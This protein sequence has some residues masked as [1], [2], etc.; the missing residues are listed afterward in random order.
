MS[1]R[2]PR[3]S[4]LGL[5]QVLRPVTSWHALGLH[6]NVPA[7]QLDDIARRLSHEGSERCKA[8]LFQL[9]LRKLPSVGWEEVIAALEKT[10]QHKLAGELKEKLEIQAAIVF[11]CSS[12]DDL[13]ADFSSLVKTVKRLLKE[14]EVKVKSVQ[15]CLKKSLNIRHSHTPQSIK[16][17]FDMIAPHFSPV[18]P[19]LL[20]CLIQKFCTMHGEVQ[21][22]LKLYNQCLEEFCYSTTMEQFAHF[23]LQSDSSSDVAKPWGKA[24]VV[25]LEVVGCWIPVSVHQ[26]HFLLSK[27]FPKNDKMFNHMTVRCCRNS[28]RISW[29]VP[30]SSVR[31]LRSLAR[32]KVH[33]MELVGVL[34]LAID[35]TMVMQENSNL[36]DFDLGLMEA[37]QAV[38]KEAISLL[39]KLGADPSRQDTQGNTALMVARKNESYDTVL[40]LLRESTQKGRV[41]VVSGNEAYFS[42]Y[43]GLYHN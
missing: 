31:L 33:M 43:G 41:C 27:M 39:L 34:F 42:S 12:A 22:Q 19:Y 14:G 9:L 11:K 3:L 13:Q 6:L 29:L 21:H 36:T 25:S 18:N 23:P 30:E 32:E 40:Q 37:V 7:H 38:D 1:D 24:A 10:S 4:V 26:F 5:L 20:V 8:E 2:M 16:E 15:R 35:G 28:L 17:L